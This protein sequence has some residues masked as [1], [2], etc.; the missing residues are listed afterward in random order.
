M[1]SYTVKPEITIPYG[2]I[3]QQ[4]GK[5]TLL[6][7]MVTANPHTTLYWAKDGR[8]LED[9]NKYEI[10]QWDVGQYTKNLGA[11]VLDLV[12]ADYGQYA[13]VASNE[14]GRDEDTVNLYGNI[15]IS[16]VNSENRY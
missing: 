12:E 8:R 13:C 11:F 3:S 2:Q 9:S 4:E 15:F 16:Y 6:E 1:C 7:C 10:H 5:D 14:H